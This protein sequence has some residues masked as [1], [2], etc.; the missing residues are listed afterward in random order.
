MGRD[1]GLDVVP[2]RLGLGPLGPVRH[3][4]VGQALGVSSCSLT[5]LVLA[6][7]LAP[8]HID[9]TT[10]GLALRGAVPLVFA[11]TAR[12]IADLLA[13][14]R[15]HPTAA[16]ATTQTT[17]SERTPYHRPNAPLTGP[18]PGRGGILPVAGSTVS[19]A[20]VSI[21]FAPATWVIAACSPFRIALASNTSRRV[22]INQR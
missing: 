22:A 15:E 4:L 9:S 13:R 8:I 19:L 14:R 1:L 17:V 6:P 16:V 7:L 5:A 12:C 3:A 21:F 18:P 11:P 2:R 20:S 10:L